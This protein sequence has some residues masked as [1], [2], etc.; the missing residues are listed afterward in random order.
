MAKHPEPPSSEEVPLYIRWSPDRSPYSIELRLGLV[1]KIAAQVNLSEQLGTEVGGFLQGTFPTAHVPTMRIDDIE[2]VSNGS[3]DDT[4]FLPEPD[5]FERFSGLHGRIRPRG[6]RI[7]GFFRTHSRT[8]PMQPSLADRSLLAQEFKNNP[9]TVLLI[10]ARA[11]H[12]AAFFVASQGQL[13]DEASVRQFEFNENEFKALPEVPAVASEDEFQH[14]DAKVDRSKLQVYLKIAAL[15]V[16]AIA[17]CALMWSFARQAYV[18]QWF[19]SASQLHLAVTPQ[20]DL[21]RISWNH[22]AKELNQATG[23]TL[24][25]TDGSSHS[26]VALGL[27]DL[28][29]GS[30]E[31]QY[32]TLRVAVRLMLDTPRGKVPGES[33][34]WTGQ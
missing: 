4:I 29:L 33:V 2:M 6:N 11:P 15:I 16:I 26:E 20:D 18:P 31:Y 34:E 19:A 28:R 7:I 21:L 1:S 23:A 9:Y 12:T 10:Q 32:A 14:A 27:D 3:E 8:G 17:A 22:A 24:L 13:P 25:I 5:E 30:V